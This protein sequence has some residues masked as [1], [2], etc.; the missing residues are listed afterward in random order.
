MT[1]LRTRSLKA[2]VAQGMV[3]I[4]LIAGLLAT[5]SCKRSDDRR[6]ERDE[7]EIRI[8]SLSPAISRTLIDFDLDRHIVGRT[9][10]CTAIDQ[11]I[12]VVGDLMSVDYE[13]IIGV[14]PTHVLVQPPAAGVDA[15]LLKLAAERGWIIADWRLN[16]L[17]DIQRMLDELPA[18]LFADDANA[19]ATMERDGS[20]IK[21]AL[22]A[23]LA[24]EFTSGTGYKAV[25]RVL[26]V[27][28]VDP[29]MAFGRGTYLDDVLVSMGGANAI[30]DAG[31]VQLSLEDVVRLEPEAIILVKP[32]ASEVDIARDLGPLAEIDVP[33]VR[34]QRLAVLRHAD[35]LLPS[36]A[37]VEVA[38]ELRSILGRF[39]AN[40]R[41]AD[42]ERE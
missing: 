1:S 11:S 33:A 40:R 39:A 13:Q 26:M 22:H 5:S 34:D 36:S 12:P 14:Q 35:A 30:N 17:N 38:S 29:V 42:N 2:F 23:A 32:G 41:A 27:N 3:A 25:Y 16:G 7:N 10:Y 37:V 24:G 4:L 8:V 15:A 20:T 28:A 31:W 9:P 6:V 18:R 19:R 21:D